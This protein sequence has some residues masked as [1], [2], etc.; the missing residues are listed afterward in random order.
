[1][2]DGCPL[3][4]TVRPIDAIVAVNGCALVKPDSIVLQGIDENLHSTGNFP[5]GIG[6]LHP[7]EQNA[8]ALVS[9]SLRG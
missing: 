5:F 9:H 4:L 1:M 8:A 2:V 7:E 6:V 3:T